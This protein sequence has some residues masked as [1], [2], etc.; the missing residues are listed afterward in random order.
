MNK[1]FSESKQKAS[2]ENVVFCV[3]VTIID[4]YFLLGE[5]TNIDEESN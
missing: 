1:Y 2:N 4:L 3:K 5:Y